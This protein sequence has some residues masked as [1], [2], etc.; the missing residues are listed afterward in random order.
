MHSYGVI[1][2]GEGSA[3]NGVTLSIFFIFFN[4]IIAPLVSLL[5]NQLK[6]VTGKFLVI[7]VTLPRGK[8]ERKSM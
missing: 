7:K 1:R 8:K 2:A 3:I 4:I 6:F 5:H